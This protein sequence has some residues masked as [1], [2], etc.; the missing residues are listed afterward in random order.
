MRWYRERRARDA[1]SLVGIPWSM[2][3]ASMPKV[4]Q[5]AGVFPDSAKE[6]AAAGGVVELVRDV[7]RAEAYRAL[8]GQVA[9]LVSAGADI[10]IP[11]MTEADVPFVQLHPDLVSGIRDAPAEQVASHPPVTVSEQSYRRDPGYRRDPRDRSRTGASMGRVG[12][13]VG[14]APANSQPQERTHREFYGAAPE[15]WQPFRPTS[16]QPVYTIVRHKLGSMAIYDTVCYPPTSQLSEDL[17]HARDEQRVVV[18]IL[19]PW[20]VRSEDYQA[21][22]R[23]LAHQILDDHP[24]AGTLV[25]FNPS[26]TETESHAGELRAELRHQLVDFQPRTAARMSEVRTHEQLAAGLVP[27]VVRAQNALMR[28]S[29]TPPAVFESGHPGSPVDGR[30]LDEAG[31]KARTKPILRRRGRNGTEQP[32]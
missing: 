13:I 10:G 20:L 24:V 3:V 28:A 9:E 6:V 7:R 14:A 11:A 4:A 31:G 26:D 19:D 27:I 25:V 32:T 29:P 23:E 21:V 16:D 2:D 15:D 18:V 5:A 8:L 1:P 22:V 12:V 30:R 17:A